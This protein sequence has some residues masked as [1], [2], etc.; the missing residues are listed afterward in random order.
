MT[1]VLSDIGDVFAAETG[2]TV[3]FSFAATS[4]L[5]RQIEHGAPASI[6]VSANRQWMQ[7]V[8]DAGLLVAGSRAVVTGNQLALIAPKDDVVIAK[9]TPALPIAQLLGDRRLALGDP[10]HVPAGK[11]AKEALTSLGLW[12]ALIGKLAPMANVRVA[13]TVVQRGEA[14]LGVVYASDAQAASKV[15]LLDLFPA[16]SHSPIIYEAALVA[17]QA[18]PAARQFM[19]FLLGPAARTLFAEHGFL[20]E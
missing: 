7:H 15:R 18:T 3:T 12:P 6:F 2:A 4:V 17:G 13:L 14:P 9:V 10:D 16:D 8:A 1:N 11:Y 19:A 5:A 20:V